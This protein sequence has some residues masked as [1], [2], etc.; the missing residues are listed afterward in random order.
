[1]ANQ[2]TNINQIA[3]NQASKEVVAN[4]NFDAAS[5]AML[6][7]RNYATTSGLVWGYYGGNY[8]VGPTAN[9]IVN[10]TLTLTA[11]ATC[12]VYAD[13]TTGAVSFNTT[14]FPANSVQL[15]SVVT[16][17]STITSWNDYRC[18]AP[19][20]IGN[21]Y[22]PSSGFIDGNFDSWQVNTTFS[23]AAATDTYTADMWLANAGTG[24]A[25][26][27]SQDT[28]AVGTEPAGMTRGR[29]YRLKFQQTTNASAA[30]TIGQKMEGVQQYNGQ[31][32]T[33]SGFLSAAVAATLVTGIQVTQNFGTG[34][35]PSASVVTTKTVSWAI[36]TAEARFSARVDIPSISSKTLGTGGNDFVRIDL[37][38]ATGATYTL[39][40]SQMQIDV[41]SP[42]AS[43]DS[44]GNGG[45]P[46]P[47][48][49]G[50]YAV[51]VPR[52]FRYLQK[53]I[54]G[55]GDGIVVGTVTSASNAYSYFP[56][57]SPMR[58]RPAVS[59]LGTLG[60]F[61]GG[62]PTGGSVSATAV[63]NS[64]AALALSGGSGGTSGYSGYF[65]SAAAGSGLIYDARL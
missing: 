19:A 45:A 15:Y 34:G 1:M 20:A 4:G 6:W 11:N 26:T 2:S 65:Y 42:N 31:S 43:A 47:F 7:G 16:G 41:C 38:L 24:G 29:K 32:I 37:L 25:A 59:I 10:G 18:Y 44:A 53:S 40:C 63:N 51:E 28:P 54:Y 62:A 39:Y 46:Q 58:A 14:G 5:P 17:A 27:V 3:S 49:W 8:Q 23:L 50:G 33:V 61:G 30:P 35:S 56:I 57:S 13:P 64:Y 12:Y 52:M 60:F 36:G 21:P 22:A 48:R 9:A 55:N